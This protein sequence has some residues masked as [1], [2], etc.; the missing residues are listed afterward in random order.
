MIG[1]G[2]SKPCIIVV[3]KC[4]NS[5][6]VFHFSP[7]FPPDDP[8][9]TLTGYSWPPGC[10]AVLCGSNGEWLSNCIADRALLGLRRAGIRIDGVIPGDACGWSFSDNRWYQNWRV[11]GL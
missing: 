10:A 2:G 6:A 8:H 4:P 3:V 5:M 11:Q 1:G 7:G 9:L